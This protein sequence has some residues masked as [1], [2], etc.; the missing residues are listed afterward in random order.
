MAKQNSSGLI[1]IAGLIILGMIVKYWSA[2][3]T[4]G[5]IGLVIWGIVKMIKSPSGPQTHTTAV[6]NSASL[7]KV[8]SEPTRLQQEKTSIPVPTF[9]IEVTTNYSRS[10]PTIYGASA[11][12][13]PPDSVWIPQGKTIEHQGYSFHSGLF[14]FGSGLQNLRGWGPEPALIDPALPIDRS[15]PD[16]EGKNMSYWPSYC[17]IHPSSRAAFL[18]WLATGRK[19][20]NAYIG[21][22]FIYFYGLERRALADTKDSASARAEIDTILTEAKQLLAIYG[23]NGS[24]GG[25][26]SKLIDIIQTSGAK[27]KLYNNSPAYSLPSYEIPFSVRVALGQMAADGMNLPAEWALAWVLTDPMTPRRTPV[28]RCREEFGKLFSLKYA[29]KYG[30]GYKLK[31]NKTKLKV[32]YRPASASFG[33]QIDIPLENAFD[34]TVLKEPISTLRLITESC[35]TELDAYSRYL[36]R[37]TSGKDSIEGAI[38]L[39]QSLLNLHEGKEYKNL[40]AWLQGQGITERPVKANL[41][42]LLPLVPS[43]SSDAFGKR[44]ATALAQVLA[45]MSVGMEPDARFG[46]FLPKA[47][48]EVVLFK[49]SDSAPNAPSTEYSAA[50]ILIHL[51]SAV[52]HADGSVAPEEERHLEEHLETLLHLSA[53]EKNRLKAHS[54][55]LL[56]SFPGLNGLK[57]RLE[58]LSQQQKESI[59]MFMVGVASADGYIDPTEIKILTKIYDLLGLDTQSVFS[60]AH[61]AAVEPVTVQVA[62]IVKP[63]YII[64]SQPVQTSSEGISL[65]MSTIEAKMAETVAVSALLKNIFADDE[66]IAQAPAIEP[67]SDSETIAGLDIETSVFM[68]M[69]ASK[70]TWERQELEQ[71]ASGQNLMLDGTLESINDASFDFFGG[72]FFEGDDPIEINSEYAKEIA[73]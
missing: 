63:A 43:I 19:D 41:A 6:K 34:V 73:V 56:H 23:N 65:N 57:K 37:K 25:Y 26:C 46:N 66:D 11:R 42:K 47:D 29:E 50:T 61:A 44:E 12:T 54:Q 49:L 72:P 64:P 67:V 20:P 68:R 70:L 36:G 8:H 52:A 71:L 59:G 1:F 27:E 48:Q 7:Q 33:G 39:P 18:E 30:D 60:H 58:A 16:R 14:Y 22:V 45:K 40:L 53:D 69:L 62:D 5:I 4:I 3:L 17:Q 24:F 35:A 28:H 10:D 9:K 31:L 55:W 21:Y 13:V 51:A 15:N 32:S 2:F 38:L